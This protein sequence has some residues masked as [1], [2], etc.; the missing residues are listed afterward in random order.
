MIKIIKRRQKGE[1]HPWLYVYDDDRISK[2]FMEK[3]LDKAIEYAEKLN[4]EPE[5]EE[6]VW[7]QKTKA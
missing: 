5:P 7:T 4:E 2:I 1:E 3:D 6:V